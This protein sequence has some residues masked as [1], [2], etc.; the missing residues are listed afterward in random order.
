[1][2]KQKDI[3]DKAVDA[4]RNEEVPSGPPE[5]LLAAVTS[6]GAQWERAAASVRGRLRLIR[7]GRFAA[8]AVLLIAA[9][10]GVGHFFR[11]GPPSVKQLQEALEPA[12]LSSL[13]PVIRDRLAIELSEQWALALAA[14]NAELREEM[15]GMGLGVL[16]ASGTLTNQRLGELI[17]AVNRAQ[18]YDRRWVTA[19][20]EQIEL[21]RVA[22]TKQ[23]ASGLQTLALHT[24]DQ[25]EQT[26][27]VVA[28]FCAR[29]Q[30]DNGFGDVEQ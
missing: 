16:A 24:E 23:L 11:P 8:A 1:M 22:D 3:V 26:M 19:A 9:G 5:E 17:E 29:R 6:Q 10:Y 20:L 25:L 4:L 7:V 14:N 30:T 28:D 27:Q 18:S 21:N 13:E 12:L 2:S 15:K